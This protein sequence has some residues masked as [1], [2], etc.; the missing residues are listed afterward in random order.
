MVKQLKMKKK[1]LLMTVVAI[2][3]LATG[4]IAQTVPSYVP[5]G[6]LVGWWSFTGNAN[7]S[8]GKGNNGTINGA[9]LTSDRFANLNSAYNF[10]GQNNN[11]V[12]PNSL[13]LN[14]KLIS[15][16]IWVNPTVFGPSEQYIIDKSND[17]NEFP[18]NRNRSW[19]I[20]IGGSGE[21]DLEIR[22]NNIYYSFPTKSTLNKNQ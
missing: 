21:L 10:N 9:T 16:S 11:I 19:A 20:R 6:G 13:N 2:L 17:D 8:S 7:D 3:G 15:V 22:V 5:K 12:I 18:A 4:I 1:N 14:P